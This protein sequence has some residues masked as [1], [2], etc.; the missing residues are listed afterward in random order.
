MGLVNWAV[1]HYIGYVGFVNATCTMA[2]FFF[3][4]DKGLRFKGLSLN[5]TTPN[6]PKLDNVPI[7]VMVIVIIHCQVSKQQVLRDK[8]PI[9][10]RRTYDQQKEEK[11]EI[12]LHKQ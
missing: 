12:H 1:T 2:L 10:A 6:P 8:K 9:K 11:M 4:C 5:T 3:N 7:N